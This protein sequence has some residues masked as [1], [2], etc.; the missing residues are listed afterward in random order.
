M[1]MSGPDGTQF[2]IASGSQPTLPGPG[3]ITLDR[4]QE[5]SAS[6]QGY[7]IAEGSTGSKVSGVTLVLSD[8]TRVVTTVGNG[9]FLAWWP[10]SAVVTSA[11]LITPSGITTQ[12]IRSPSL[13]PGSSSGINDP[14]AGASS[15][16][17]AIQRFCAYVNAHNIHVY[18]GGP[19]PCETIA[20]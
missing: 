18:F 1:C 20:P 6:G 10:G 16:S 5:A 14:L 3:Q 8:G 11:T 17:E 13:D 9:L 4:L 19:D 2:S 12:A 15:Q 7:T